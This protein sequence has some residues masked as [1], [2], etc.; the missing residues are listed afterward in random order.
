MSEFSNRTE[1]EVSP[2]LPYL[3]CGRTEAGITLCYLNAAGRQLF[4]VT[5]DVLPRFQELFASPSREQLSAR[6]ESV[7]ITGQT[8]GIDGLTLSVSPAGYHSDIIPLTDQTAA[9]RLKPT[10]TTFASPDRPSAVNPADSGRIEEELEGQNRLRHSLI[11][12]LQ[13][14]LRADTLKKG[15]RASLSYFGTAVR[16]DRAFVYTI[17]QGKNQSPTAILTHEWN[18]YN[19]RRHDP[20]PIAME[21]QITNPDGELYRELMLRHAVSAVRS[22]ANEVTREI[23]EKWDF[24]SFLIF[25][26][27]VGRQLYGFVGVSDLNRERRWTEAESDVLQLYA[28][29]IALAVELDRREQKLNEMIRRSRYNEHLLQTGE[30][31]YR[32]ILAAIPDL[33]F[34]YDQAGNILDYSAGNPA[35]LAVPPE[36]FMKQPCGKILPPKIAAMFISGIRQVTTRKEPVNFQYELVINDDRRRFDA[37]MVPFGDDKAMAII[38]NVTEEQ[39]MKKALL[40]SEN[41]LRLL[42]D[43]IPF[44]AA[45]FT[46]EAGNARPQRYRFISVNTCYE[47]FCGRRREA[48]CGRLIDEVFPENCTAWNTILCRL[49]SPDGKTEY[50]EFHP[51]GSSFHFNC[52][53]FRPEEG[54]DYFCVIFNDITSLKQIQTALTLAKNKAEES[55]RL[56]SAFLSNMSHE[57]RT[58]LNTIVGMANLIVEQNPPETERQQYA[59]LINQSSNQLLALISDIIDIAKI[60]S[61]QLKISKHN[62]CVNNLIGKLHEAFLAQ[63]FK[64]PAKALQLRC[65][66]PL[67]HEEATI[68]TDETRLNQVLTNLL[69]NAVKF[70]RQG[71]VEVGYCRKEESREMVFFVKDTG[72]G[73][74]PQQQ[75]IIFERFRQADD[76][77]TRLYGGTGLGLAICKNLVE[78]MG[79]R[80][81]LES[82]ISR[83]S[84][85]YF[86]LPYER[87]EESPVTGERSISAMM[88]P[89]YSWPD[90]KVLLVEDTA[91]VLYYLKRVLELADIQCLTAGN[92]REA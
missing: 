22:S 84:C 17:Y 11:H 66:C 92:G 44:A 47:H 5:D 27:F 32:S 77:F 68:Y 50:L 90:R 88:S 40:S 83:G 57:I 6:I 24:Y 53:A 9:V 21:R 39:R 65:S 61:G 3:I 35:D 10:C 34:V 33:L 74:P 58:P 54:K 67:S 51:P 1:P 89:R 80:I 86:S 69:N 36:V 18:H 2:E 13:P 23:M 55:D 70:T 91:T 82:A 79:G 64:M 62:L 31:R 43:R 49:S 73:I 15:I 52:S 20:A 60:E 56:K 8:D 75:S 16:A 37:R 7:L 41:R 78:L 42:F 28:E 4:A 26:I 85:F 25:P 71:S 46:P 45:I 30:M 76:S 14:L 63:L 38:R 81:W 72:P 29:S 59:N 19:V 12:C 87:K 48:L